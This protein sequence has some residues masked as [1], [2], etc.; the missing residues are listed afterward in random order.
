MHT[1]IWLSTPNENC[2]ENS[3]SFGDTSRHES[4]G[5]GKN[6]VEHPCNNGK[7]DGEFMAR[8]D[9][10]DVGKNGNGTEDGNDGGIIVFP[11]CGSKCSIAEEDLDG[12]VGR[13]KR[14]TWSRGT[15][16][17]CG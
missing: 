14:L 6:L 15:C 11:T 3:L 5:G 7:A 10:T 17:L 13:S 12:R 4:S 16:S 1:L 8:P 2:V 9:D